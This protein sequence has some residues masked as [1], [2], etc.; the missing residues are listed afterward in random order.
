METS[1]DRYLKDIYYDPQSPA[2]FSGVEKLWSHIKYRADKPTGLTKA[3][4]KLWLTYQDTDSVHQQSRK[5]FPRERIIVSS[6]D[7]Q[8]DADLADM[9]GVKEFNDG[10]TFILI[11]IDLLSRYCWMRPLKTKKG[12]EVKTAF[13]DI[14]DTDRRIPQRLRTDRGK[15]FYNKNVRE[16]LSSK[17]V[18][19]FSTSSIQKA[20]YCERLIRTIK[21]KIYKFMYDRQTFRY[22]DVLQDIA[23]SY[24]HSLHGATGVTPA[25]VTEENDLDLYMR[26]Y[27]PHVNKMAGETPKFSF[28]VGDLV[29]KAYRKGPFSRSY[30]ENFSEE[31]FKIIYRVNSHPPR[32]LLADG[33]ENREPGSFYA[34]QLIKVP[35]DDHR[36]YKIE[37]VIKTRK[38]GKK[39]REALIKWYGYS[40]KF[41]SWLPESQVKKYQSGGAVTSPRKGTRRAKNKRR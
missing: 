25:S 5:K 32:Y 20:N 23:F 29:R 28:N 18:H 30:Q 14:F 16:Y 8:W 34:Q 10:V 17:D 38:V 35:D 36:M 21:Q 24:N 31:I 19:H 22:I 33:L 6:L 13:A 39:K 1:I 12:P 27:M 37:K 2:S 41:N 11:T 26:K 9:S 3:K 7:M 15:E 4:I 40:D